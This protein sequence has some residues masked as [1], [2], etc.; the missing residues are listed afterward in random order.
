MANAN[1]N[2]SASSSYGSNIM[3]AASTVEV[4]TI[5]DASVPFHGESPHERVHDF[6]RSCEDVMRGFNT[7]KD[8]DKIS[9]VRSKLAAQEG[10][11]PSCAPRH[12]HDQIVQV[13][14]V[15]DIHVYCDGSVNGSRSRCGLFMRDYIFPN[16][17]TDTEVSRRFSAHMSST[18]AELYAVLEALHIVAPLH[19]NVYLFVDSQAALYA[20]QFTSPHGL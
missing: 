10:L 17:S 9:L 4:L 2:A 3:Q 1:V 6:I 19:M 15:Q 16:H 7:V 5:S 13:P 11:A 20:L 14:H 12:V 8:E 18:R